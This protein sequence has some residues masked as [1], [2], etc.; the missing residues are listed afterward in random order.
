[1]TFTP[2]ESVSVSVAKATGLWL[3]ES[4]V[5]PDILKFADCADDAK[6]EKKVRKI[7]RQLLIRI[8]NCSNVNGNVKLTL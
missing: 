8:R 2:V 1:M 4:I 3:E 5:R 7:S 6:A